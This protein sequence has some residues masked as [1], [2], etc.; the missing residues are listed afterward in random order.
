MAARA[1]IEHLDHKDPA[2]P[3]KTSPTH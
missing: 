1:N 2:P 3:A